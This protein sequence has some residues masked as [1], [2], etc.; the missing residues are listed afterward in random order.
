MLEEVSEVEQDGGGRIWLF[1]TVLSFS[2]LQSFRFLPLG[3]AFPP[4]FFAAIM[5]RSSQASLKAFRSASDL[6]CCHRVSFKKATK[7]SSR[8]PHSVS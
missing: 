2:W 6:M 8:C 3:A 5:R 7:L 4:V 1:T